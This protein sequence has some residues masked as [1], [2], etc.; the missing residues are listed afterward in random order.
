MR[1]STTFTPTHITGKEAFNL[2]TKLLFDR[3]SKIWV[4]A[5]H[6]G[7]FYIKF[8]NG[9]PIYAQ[10]TKK[11]GAEG[12]SRRRIGKPRS[13][14]FA[15]LSH[16]ALNTDGGIFFIPGK[17]SKFPLKKYCLDSDLLSA[18]MDD[19]TAEEQWERLAWFRE[20][21]GLDFAAI[22]HSG[23]KSYHAHVKLEQKV[24]IDAR[25]HLQK[26]LALILRSDPAVVNPHQPMRLPGFDRREKGKHQTLVYHSNNQFSYE[27]V[28]AG[29]KRIFA[30]LGWGFHQKLSDERWAVL[31]RV[32]T[33]KLEVRS[34]SEKIEALREIFAKSDDDLK[35]KPK[36]RAKATAEVAQPDAIISNA[37]AVP[38]FIPSAKIPG[39]TPLAEFLPKELHQVWQQGLS[40]GT[41]GREP[42]LFKLAC[43][44]RGIIRECDRAGITYHGNPVQLL[45]DYANRCNPPIGE[46]VAAKWMGKEE[47]NFGEDYVRQKHFWHQWKEAGSPKGRAWFEWCEQNNIKLPEQS[48]GV[49]QKD[50]AHEEWLASKNFTPNDTQD[51]PFVEFDLPPIG[52]SLVVKSGLGTGKT[53]RLATTIMPALEMEFGIRNALAKA[54]KSGEGV[55]L[56]GSRNSLLIQICEKLGILHYQS[57]K[58]L[59]IIE[60]R[61][62][63]GKIAICTNSLE[64]FENPEWFMNKLLICDEFMPT[65]SHLLLSKTHK[66]NRKK[67]IDLFTTCLRTTSRRIFL[68]GHAAD[69]AVDYLQNLLGADHPI[70]KLE[71]LYK[72]ERPNVNFLLGTREDDEPEDK[73]NT[74]DYSPIIKAIYASRRFG[75]IS[76]SQTLL[77]GLET[78]LK[79]SGLVGIRADSKTLSDELHPARDF[80]KDCKKWI[81]ENKPDYILISPSLNAGIDIPNRGYFK[82]VY[83]LFFGVIGTDQQRQFP[84]RFRDPSIQHHFWCRTHGFK[85]NLFTSP[86]STTIQAKLNEYL[87]RDIKSIAERQAISDRLLAE[88]DELETNPHVQQWSKLVAIDNYE[89]AN[90]R[91]CFREMLDIDGYHVTDFVL[92]PCQASK[93]A[94]ASAKEDV[95]LRHAEMIF[96]ARDITSEEAEAIMASMCAK[97]EDQCAAKRR[98]IL[99]KLPGIENT[100]IWSVDF[101]LEM[102]VKDRQKVQALEKCYYLNNPEDA[103][104]K[105]QNL[106]AHIA[107]NGDIFLPD[108]NSD[109]LFSKALYY[110]GIPDLLNGEQVEF[111]AEDFKSLVKRASHKK[112]VTALGFKPG[113][114]AIKYVQKLLKLVGARLVSIRRSRKDGLARIYRLVT[115]CQPNPLEKNDH[116]SKLAAYSM[117]VYRGIDIRHREMQARIEA[118]EKVAAWDEFLSYFS[119][120]IFGSEKT[121]QSHTG[122]GVEGDP[123]HQ[124]SYINSGESGSPQT[125]EF[126]IDEEGI[127]PADITAPTPAQLAKFAAQIG[128]E[129]KRGRPANSSNFIKALIDAAKCRGWINKL[130]RTVWVSSSLI[131]NWLDE[132]CN[133]AQYV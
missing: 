115:P 9:T 64:I 57:N 54:E 44:F 24:A 71:N 49:K 65:I 121:P 67:C 51:R 112:V 88:L 118:S 113:E 3:D 127:H 132:G 29:F 117:A 31:R 89:K 101:I 6:S 11:F 108:V 114:D 35:F 86:F 34:D 97:E 99:D 100:A 122:G 16:V 70:I 2:A 63:N 125:G 5:G 26:L 84:V 116:D 72:P 14:V 79:A 78:D 52:S 82:N 22:V 39:S 73:I 77:E 36:L 133:V 119:P 23:S 40:A 94:L 48:E 61:K 56:L 27:E 7:F 42:H 93:K 12:E 58:D 60:L 19:G 62:P 59:A 96:N 128:N 55:I 92:A 4:K 102:F 46:L 124:L 45:Y 90:L 20:V 33:N 28:I 47:S 18:E 13:D 109:H 80:V 91:A 83:G 130:T 131:F 17:P 126:L 110:L 106:W 75:V 104:S 95:L 41:A 43:A 76:D 74:N 87:R 10:A 1:T 25:T 107:L 123:D 105:Q 120:E 98:G 32:V 111:T 85:N 21:S 38:E 68:D 37:V 103:K 15:V 50:A 129:F 69:H 53:H 30:A 81:N 66:R 8:E